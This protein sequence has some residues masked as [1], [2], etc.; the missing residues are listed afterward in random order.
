MTASSSALAPSPLAEERRALLARVVEG[1]DAPTLWWLSGYTAGLAHGQHAPQLAVLPGG[2]AQSGQRLTV[3][4]GSQTGNARRAA[5]KIAQEVEAGGLPVRL[6]RADAYP[7]REL[8][9]ERL[10]YV[11]ISTQG[12]G[13]PPDDSRALVDFLSGK[14]APGSLSWGGINNTYFWIDP[15]RNVTGVILMQL[16]PFAD[17]LCLEAFA[18]FERGFDRRAAHQF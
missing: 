8:A 10:L 14:R 17:K 4:Y 3:I 11:V 2:Q 5:E 1:L 6:L 18:G 16:L 13:D 15:A 7:T 12:D 9:N